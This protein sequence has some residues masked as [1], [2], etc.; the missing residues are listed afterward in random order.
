M[1]IYRDIKQYM[2][3]AYRYVYVIKEYTYIDMQNKIIYLYFHIHMSVCLSD[4]FV[5]YIQKIYNLLSYLFFIIYYE[6]LQKAVRL[7]LTV[8]LYIALCYLCFCHLFCLFLCMS[9]SQPVF[10]FWSI[11]VSGKSGTVLYH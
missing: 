8:F 4:S 7:W 9:L 2:Y 5:S 6:K 10:L 1:F 3:I 11:S